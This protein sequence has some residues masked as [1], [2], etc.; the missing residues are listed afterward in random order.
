L[1]LRIDGRACVAFGAFEARAATL[2]V[3]R[4]RLFSCGGCG[5]IH[6]QTL[7]HLQVP[8]RLH[9]YMRSVRGMIWICILSL[10][11]HLDTESTEICSAQ[12]GCPAGRGPGASCKHVAA[13]CYAIAN[14]CSCGRLPGFLTCTERLQEW[15]KPRGKRVEA[16]PVEEFGSRKQRLLGQSSNNKDKYQK[17]MI[18]VLY[19]FVLLTP[20]NR[21][22]ES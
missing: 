4:A 2:L 21:T 3:S 10:R 15:N 17:S 12:C 11:L 13:L 7:Y 9:L 6:T 8:V 20:S 16:I 1:T 22:I 14:F 5:R 19:L 18:L